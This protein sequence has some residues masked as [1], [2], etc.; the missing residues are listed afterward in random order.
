[1][2][3]YEKEQPTPFDS[4]PMEGLWYLDGD[5]VAREI[6]RDWTKGQKF[7]LIV[8]PSKVECDIWPTGN[9]E[10][11]AI[12]HLFGEMDLPFGV[13][14]DAAFD[15]AND[16][17]EQVGYFANR[18]GDDTIEVWGHDSSEHYKVVFDNEAHRMVNVVPVIEERTPK[19]VQPLLDDETKSKLPKLYTNED[20]GLDAPALVKFFT[21]DS[22]WTWYASEGSVIEANRYS[23]AEEGEQ[24][25]LM[26]GLVIGF[27]IELGYFSLKELQ[28]ARG[29]MGLPIERDR[30]FEPK[31]L[32]EL[33]ETHSR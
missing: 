15:S 11:I 6:G 7:P 12:V 5:Q 9:P 31:T 23:N 10:V 24:D 22:N 21:P 17:A 3:W 20:I 14:R 4:Q 16:I 8:F 19:P 18:V 30:Y 32:R 29:P 28:E 13:D 33:Q 25:F 1:M 2:T 27:E 26:F